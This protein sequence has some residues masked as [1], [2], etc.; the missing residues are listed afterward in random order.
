M[1][2]KNSQRWLVAKWPVSMLAMLLSLATASAFGATI[3]IV[4]SYVQSY[5]ASFAPLGVLGNDGAAT[6]VGDYLQYEFRMTLNGATPGEDFW[7]AIFNI[8]LGAGLQN[9]SGWLDP[10]TAQANGYYPANPSLATFDS[11]GAAPGGVQ[12]SWQYSNGDYGA[13]PN[14][15]Q[16]IIIE[17]APGEAANRQ[18]GEAGRPGDGSPDGLGSP[19]LLGTILVQRTAFVSSSVTLAPIAGSPWGTYEGN[20]QGTGLPTAQSGTSFEGGTITLQIPEPGAIGL[21]LCA[22]ATSLVL[23][24]RRLRWGS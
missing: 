19:T 13:N 16:S 15:L 11:N 22:A 5:D 14:D 7:T 8:Q 3:S 23:G 21:A 12:M 9:T 18:Y 17:A 20:S 6:P 4:P 24:R 1:I 10:A 2:A